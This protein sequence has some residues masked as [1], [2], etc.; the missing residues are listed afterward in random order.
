MY[1]REQ[2]LCSIT[3][4]LELIAVIRTC[5]TPCTYVHCFTSLTASFGLALLLL[6]LYTAVAGVTLARKEW[7]ETVARSLSL[8]SQA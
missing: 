3:C 7:R 5:R 8:S 6:F 2:I 1:L 4:N